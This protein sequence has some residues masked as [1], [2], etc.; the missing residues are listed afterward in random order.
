MNSK[1]EQTYWAKIY[2]AG[3]YDKARDICRQ[4]CQ[5]VGLAVNVIANS[6]IY[7]G[8]EENGVI[9]E[10]LNYPRFPATW[11]DI[12]EKAYDLG[13][14]LRQGLCQD[15]FMLVTPQDTLWVTSRTEQYNPKMATPADA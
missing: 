9:V 14:E 7:T 1:I 11:D 3:D 4:Y 10:I 5:K 13:I 12:N 2:I 15:S 8:G 6:Y